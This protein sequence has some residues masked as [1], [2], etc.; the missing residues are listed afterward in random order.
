[1]C[2]LIDVVE[3]QVSPEEPEANTLTI[4]AVSFVINHNV[5]AIKDKRISKTACLAESWVFE[6][7][8]EGRVVNQRGP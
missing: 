6:I 2:Q 7:R 3:L 8:H 1:M 4:L 5:N